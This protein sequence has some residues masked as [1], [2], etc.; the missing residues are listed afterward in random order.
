MVQRYYI[1]LMYTNN[2]HKKQIFPENIKN[3]SGWR[4][5]LIRCCRYEI[6]QQESQQLQQLLQRCR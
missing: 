4:V 5:A 3:K 2:L 6:T 1:F